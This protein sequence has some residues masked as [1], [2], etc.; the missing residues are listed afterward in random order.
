MRD[1]QIYHDDIII[2]IDFYSCRVDNFFYV[3][4]DDD[5]LSYFL[6]SL[7]LKVI[8][9]ISMVDFRY[10]GCKGVDGY[11]FDDSFVSIMGN[12]FFICC[13]G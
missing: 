3:E 8:H 6:V 5:I 2:I 1:M 12:G 4:D 13:E 9:C 10:F 11:N 7:S